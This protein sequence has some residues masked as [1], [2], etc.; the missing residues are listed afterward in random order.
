MIDLDERLD[1]AST[2]VRTEV[3]SVPV[4][5]PAEF[6]RRR[7]RSRTMAVASGFVA[8]AVLL[9]GSSFILGGG[10][11]LAGQGTEPIPAHTYT[12]DIPGWKLSGVW[13][14]D[15]GTG[16]SHSLF[17][18]A[19]SSEDVLRSVKI[20]SG[21]AAV[22]RH[23]SLQTQGIQP[24]RSIAL[25]GSDATLY[26]T[27]DDPQLGWATVIAIWTG[28][29]DEQ[30]AVLFVDIGLEEASDLLTGLMPLDIHAWQS[31]T[32]AYVPPVSTTITG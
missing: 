1:R 23:E 9:F 26:L 10:S 8:V 28:P 17:D 18:E 2:A 6:V 27:G 22:E 21:S 13:E 12:V 25:N 32:T 11:E 14:S 31:L 30:V 19:G 29:H 3:S 16:R 5:P 20:D 4:R 15:D 24:T 7:H